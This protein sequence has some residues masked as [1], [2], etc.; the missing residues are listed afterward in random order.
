MKLRTVVFL[1]ALAFA[2]TLAVVVGQRL[3]S[4]AMAVLLGVIA[5]VAAS[6]P[7]SLIVVWFA[8]RTRPGPMRT[9]EVHR[10]D[11]RPRERVVVVTQPQP[12]TS[13]P[14]WTA[15]PPPAGP[16]PKRR[17]FTIIGGE[18]SEWEL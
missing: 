5:G 6:I 4:E 13:Q 17:H 15:Q 18:E 11:D 3:S 16:V 7:T 2:I 12:P 1:A 8:T 14:A 9:V 10:S